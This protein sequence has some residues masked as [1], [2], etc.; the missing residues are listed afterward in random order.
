MLLLQSGRAAHCYSPSKGGEASGPSLRPSRAP[1]QPEV[2]G[3]GVSPTLLP[4]LRVNP[5]P[6]D[7]LR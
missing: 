1:P 7:D 5:F 6:D 4:T 3:K 2:S